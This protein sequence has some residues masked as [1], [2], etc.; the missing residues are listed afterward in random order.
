M[1]INL[2]LDSF[3]AMVGANNYGEVRL[4]LKDGGL[5]KINQHFLQRHNIGRIEVD[6]NENHIIREAFLQ[7]IAGKVDPDTYRQIRS[8]LGITALLKTSRDNHDTDVYNSSL[9]RRE[10]KAILDIVDRKAFV[11]AKLS[12]SMGAIAIRGGGPTFLSNILDIYNNKHP[13]E[14]VHATKDQLK[15]IFERHGLELQLAAGKAEKAKE[16]GVTE[17]VAGLIRSYLSDETLIGSSALS[18][19]QRKR[20]NSEKTQLSNFNF[21]S[22]RTT[23]MSLGLKHQKIQEVNGQDRTKL[24]FGK[25]DF[26]PF[27]WTTF[28]LTNE[29]KCARFTELK[30]KCGNDSINNGKHNELVEL[31][32]EE[33]FSWAT[34]NMSRNPIKITIGDKAFDGL[35]KWGHLSSDKENERELR[36]LRESSNEKILHDILAEIR[37]LKKD[38]TCDQYIALTRIVNQLAYNLP[39]SFG[40][41]PGHYNDVRATVS[42]DDKGPHVSFK[43]DKPKMENVLPM[44]LKYDVDERGMVHVTSA[45]VCI[46]QN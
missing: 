41:K 21:D 11:D 34:Y 5:E 40:L 22:F 29:A 3:R 45:G 38:M 31:I 35:E 44:E 43:W 33:I 24:H 6:Q 2:N 26:V 46:D 9:S 27:C 42:V 14:Q 39:T 20:S 23:M 30:E 28:A 10:I 16:G 25:D 32:E 19:S 15:V 37:Q 36:K 18:G 12:E 1:N 13:N 7:S 17:T 8:R 4:N